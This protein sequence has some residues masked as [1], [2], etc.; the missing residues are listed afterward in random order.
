[1]SVQRRTLSAADARFILTVPEAVT[2]E[3][4]SVETPEK[5]CIFVIVAEAQVITL[6]LL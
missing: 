6:Y 2:A 1:V 3:V 5:N 4:I